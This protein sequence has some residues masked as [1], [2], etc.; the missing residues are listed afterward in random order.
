MLLLLQLCY[1]I[2]WI[3][4][5]QTFQIIISKHNNNINNRLCRSLPTRPLNVISLSSSL[6]EEDYSSPQL[7]ENYYMENPLESSNLEW[8]SSISFDVLVK[9]CCHIE[10]FDLFRKTTKTD[11]IV[12]T[13]SRSDISD[14]I[15]DTENG[16]N[17]KRIILMIG[18]GTS[19]FPDAILSQQQHNVYN[20]NSVNMIL[21]DSSPSCI[22]MLKKRYGTNHPQIQYMC[23]NFLEQ[24]DGGMDANVFRHTCKSGN[25][26]YDTECTSSSITILDKGLM[27]ALFCSDNWETLVTKLMQEVSRVLLSYNNNNDKYLS[28][29]YILVSYKLS[30]SK[31]QFLYDVGNQV[32]L[33][34]NFNTSGSNNH[35]WISVARIKQR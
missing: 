20:N 5:C 19:R 4:S 21:L 24:S 33:E 18:C 1:F 30:T 2:G 8:H 15:H 29:Y 14:K 7:W 12:P 25:D 32:Q 16:K 9:Y 23:G 35:V 10:T 26:D 17:D 27:D 3:P 31:Q 6:L 11:R 13:P 22:N 28:S 34:W